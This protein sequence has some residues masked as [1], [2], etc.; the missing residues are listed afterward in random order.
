MSIFSHVSLPRIKNSLY[1][2]NFEHKLSYRMADLIPLKV[3]PV[4][5]GDKIINL[6]V[7]SFTRMAPMIFPVMHR[8][9]IKLYAFFV[10]N[11]L[12]WEEWEDYITGGPEGS[13]NPVKPFIGI[14][15]LVQKE[16]LDFIKVGSLM[17]YM[18]YPVQMID[19]TAQGQTVLSN[20]VFKFHDMKYRGYQLI[21][22]EYFRD[23]NLQ[24]EI[25]IPQYGGDEFLMSP[26]AA[27]EMLT[28]R[29]KCWQ[30][31]Y[32]TSA[33]PWLQRGPLTTMPVNVDLSEGS[34]ELSDT[35]SSN[36]LNFRSNSGAAS[37]FPNVM[38]SVQEGGDIGPLSISTSG[39]GK[40]SPVNLSDFLDAQL[41]AENPDA[42]SF[43][44]EDLRRAV[45][46]QEW[47]E[48][49]A[50]GGARYTEQ[51]LAHFGVRSSDARLQRPEF[52]GATSQ[53]ISISEVLQSS[54]STQDGTPL[55]EMGGHGISARGALLCKNKFFEEH[56]YVFVLMSCIPRTGY[57][58]GIDRDSLKFDKFEEYWQEFAHI[59][60]QPIYQDELWCDGVQM[61]GQEHK[62]FGY[63]PRYAEYQ[64]FPDTVAG[65]FRTTLKS[66]HMA[67]ELS[68]PALNGDFVT[69]NPTDRIF[70]VQYRDVE[71]MYAQFLFHLNMRRPV[72]KGA[73]PRF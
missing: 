10:P 52:L 1:R 58:Q 59:G 47:R 29:K 27:R 55:G 28:L 19:K 71:Q 38:H 63:T 30:K 39:G 17:D 44:I 57:F 37:D 54:E 4:L 34:V 16:N 40:L 70:P 69:A 65:E 11:R 33:L 18:G 48:R 53:P 43:L 2:Y 6:G 7:E 73:T 22:N 61:S 46:L 60:E 14:K 32:F 68:K 21:W 42:G 67:R 20:S 3:F 9:N 64:Y 36:P 41:S 24:D 51:I 25:V 12:I 15:H 49:N 5:P 56:G 50:R 45:K 31:D 35:R 23:Q 72:L 62:I 66:W 8:M 26:D 13:L